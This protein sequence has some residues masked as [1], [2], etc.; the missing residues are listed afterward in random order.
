MSDCARNT[1]SGGIL[2]CHKWSPFSAV[3]FHVKEIQ[4][5]YKCSAFVPVLNDTRLQYMGS[6]MTM[7]LVPGIQMVHRFPSPSITS[8]QMFWNIICFLPFLDVF[9]TLPDV[10]DEALAASWWLLLDTWGTNDWRSTKP[11]NLKHCYCQKYQ[12]PSGRVHSD[13]QK[14]NYQE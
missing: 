11:K 6:M 8:I 2:I 14:T 4:W 9:S 5:I 3:L 12:W 10:K 1:N 7:C 13:T